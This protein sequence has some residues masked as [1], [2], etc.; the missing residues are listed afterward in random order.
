VK[1]PG[2]DGDKPHLGGAS[3]NYLEILPDT[4]RTHGDKLISGENF[5]N[6]P[7][8]IA[9][10]DYSV[11]I[12]KAGRYY[13]W[14][15]AYSTGSEDNGIHLGLDGEWPESGQRMQ[16][17]Q[18]KNR[19]YWES[20]QRTQKQHCGVPHQIYLDIKKPGL[21]TIS[22]SMREDG[23]EFGQFLL[24]RDRDFP[25]LD[26]DEPKVAKS[27]AA[28][29]APRGRNGGGSVEITGAL[30]PWLPVTLTL[31]GPFADETDN[32]PNPFT[33]LEMSVRFTHESGSP[34][35]TVSGYF[36]ADGDAANTGASSGNKWRAH[37]SPDK[38]GTWRYKVS[39]AGKYDGKAGSF[40]VTAGDPLARAHLMQL[41]KRYLQAAGSGEYFLKAGADAPETLLAYADF[42]GTIGTKSNAPLKHY[43]AHVRDW[44]AGDPTWGND[45][46][47][48]LIGAINYLAGK[49]VDAFL[50]LTYNAGGDGNNVWPFISRDD[51]L[52]YDCSKLDQWAIV[53]NYASAKGMYA[54]FKLQE[55][56]MDDKV[57]TS[58]D[59]GDF[60]P[61]R[62]LYCREIVAR[63]AHLQAL[64]WNLGEENTQ[65]TKQQR[66]MANAIHDY[67]PY[68]HIIV[69]HTFPAQQER[70]YRPLMGDGSVLRG[71]SLQNSAIK[72]THWQTV[73][74]VKETEATGTP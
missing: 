34:D 44:Q 24:T 56:E 42:D 37:L 47:K 7:G 72:G 59:R 67:D 63:F 14:V 23:F 73:K 13:V 10:L 43:K 5:S 51:K 16:W 74:W 32:A 70:V 65:S 9:I 64:N 35:Y 8:R 49:G 68:D 2:P 27:A 39:F 69:V 60:G 71:M 52:H 29:S 28:N 15:R 26:S 33:D 55:T 17:C 6:E 12:P 58:L 30:K 62:R 1:A 50:F 31:D 66:D 36:A 46:G 19:W 45:N 40:V 11:E 4:R 41:G 20:K 61:E 38:S 18:G 53:L 25:R 21:Q 22:F 57:P 3:G 48:G 54:H